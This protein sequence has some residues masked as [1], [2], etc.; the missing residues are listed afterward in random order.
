MCFSCKLWMSSYSVSQA[1]LRKFN[2]NMAHK[3]SRHSVTA[4][5]SKLFFP[6]FEFNTLR[7]KY[8]C[9]ALQ[10]KFQLILEKKTSTCIIHGTQK[11]FRHIWNTFHFLIA[12]LSC[13][14]SLSQM[15]FKCYYVIFLKRWKFCF[16]NYYKML[17]SGFVLNWNKS[18]I[19]IW[20]KA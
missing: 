7:N 2:G 11:Y 17:K 16:R 15:L 8:C 4:K 1:A 10:L 18:K 19:S 13:S 20:R 3:V 6:A 12:S 9:V 5:I 14:S